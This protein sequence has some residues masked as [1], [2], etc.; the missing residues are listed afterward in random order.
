LLE[1]N[2]CW[3]STDGIAKGAA[4]TKFFVRRSD[5]LR[6]LFN[7]SF[8]WIGSSSDFVK[9]DVSREEAELM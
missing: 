7:S 8:G 9:N 6:T 3:V 1:R 4:A 5:E 2:R